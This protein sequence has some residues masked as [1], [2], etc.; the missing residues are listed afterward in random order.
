MKMKPKITYDDE[1]GAGY[2]K[3]RK[4]LSLR[5]R[6]YRA[7]GILDYDEDGNLLGIELLSLKDTE[8][9]DFLKEFLKQL[10][11]YFRKEG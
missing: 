5:C 6:E 9:K 7:W 1:G 11:E 10:Q 2:I 8:N 3:L 4:G